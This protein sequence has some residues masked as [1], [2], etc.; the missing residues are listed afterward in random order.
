MLKRY[1]T[2]QYISTRAGWY[3]VTFLAAVTINFFLPRL[4]AANPVD[5]IM[6]KVGAGL[7]TESAKDKEESYLK[8]FGLV[9]L[10]KDGS[11]AR[12]ASGNPVRTTLWK[13]F[14]IYIGMS[15]K[16]DLGTSFNQYPKKVTEI[17]KNAVP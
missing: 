13:Q 10:N 8:E 9:E 4:G 15:L 2:L 12:D 7:D 11:L 5:I 17:I 14:G 6:A 1:P 16:G 3:F